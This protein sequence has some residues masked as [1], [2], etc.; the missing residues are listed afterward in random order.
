MLTCQTF[1]NGAKRFGGGSH[2][3]GRKQ[4]PRFAIQDLSDRLRRESSERPSNICRLI[5]YHMYLEIGID[6]PKVHGKQLARYVV[7]TDNA[8]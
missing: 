1:A 6:L 3:G 7:D 5:T 8:A 4:E 2:E